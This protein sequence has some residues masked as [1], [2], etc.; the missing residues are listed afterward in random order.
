MGTGSLTVVIDLDNELA[1][2]QYGAWDGYPEGQGI[3]ALNILK[4]YG[5]EALAIGL[6]YTRFATEREIKTIQEKYQSKDGSMTVE[7]SNRFV[8]DHPGLTGDT[9]A[10]ILGIIIET[11]KELLLTNLYALKEDKEFV[12]GYYEINLHSG[13]FFTRFGPNEA[14][15]DLDN[16]PAPEDYLSVLGRG[17]ID[18]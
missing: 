4:S 2:A 10:K 17:N 15:F 12:K 5:W 14:V 1:V 8:N 16:L 9:G 3:T 18:E 6:T 11:S 13:K 7:E